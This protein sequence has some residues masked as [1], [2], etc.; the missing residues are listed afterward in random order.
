VVESIVVH[1]YQHI[2]VLVRGLVARQRRFL[3]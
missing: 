1:F 3:H 2:N